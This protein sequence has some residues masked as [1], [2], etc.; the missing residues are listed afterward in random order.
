MSAQQP[1]SRPSRRLPAGHTAPAARTVLDAHH[2]GHNRLRRNPTTGR[3]PSPS[4]T[5]ADVSRASPTA[6]G[7][8]QR[9]E[10]K[11]NYGLAP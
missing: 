5:S 7:P 11:I 6:S 1:H 10:R 9:H 8:D 3:D 2:D 4:V